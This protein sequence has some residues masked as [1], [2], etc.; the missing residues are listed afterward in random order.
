MSDLEPVID[1]GNSLIDPSGAD[2]FDRLSCE[3]N[4]SIDVIEASAAAFFFR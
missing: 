4:V 3:I 1:L 2:F